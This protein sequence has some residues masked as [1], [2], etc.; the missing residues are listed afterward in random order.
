MVVGRSGISLPAATCL[1]TEMQVQGLNLSTEQYSSRFFSDLGMRKRLQLLLETAQGT[2]GM[3]PEL[4]EH[5]RL[6]LKFF[7]LTLILNV[8]G[9][10]SLIGQRKD[11]KED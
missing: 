1:I 4:G 10:P 5:V 6:C 8:S 11:P 3:G 9:S 7:Y 2:L